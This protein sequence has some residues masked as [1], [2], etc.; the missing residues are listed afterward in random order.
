METPK[1]ESKPQETL[2][3]PRSD[4]LAP[5]TPNLGAASLVQIWE[6][7][8]NRSNS[9]NNSNSAISPDSALSCNE[10]NAS[11]SSSPRSSE[12]ET[13]QSVFEERF[14][15]S[16]DWHSDRTAPSEQPSPCQSR[17]SDAGES[18]RVRVA[19]IIKRLTAAN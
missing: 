12:S 5:E 6:K 18:E 14:D 2:L 9:L 19:D 17:N 13:G 10:N 8:L 11:S 15:S 3:L 16:A 7:R 4:I 1:A